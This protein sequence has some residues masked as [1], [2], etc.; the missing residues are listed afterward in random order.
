MIAPDK[1]ENGEF[2]HLIN[3]YLFNDRANIVKFDQYSDYY[4]NFERFFGNDIKNSAA[5][6][7]VD[8]LISSGKTFL[9][10]SDMINNLQ[11][12]ENEFET[13]IKGIFC[14]LNLLDYECLQ[15]VQKRLKIGI[16]YSF[17]NHDSESEFV[18]SLV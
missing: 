9:S 3:R 8:N 11:G 5:I 15:N 6:Y 14:L 12:I 16:I 10:L 2:L 4:L 18:L 7:Y 17:I 13:P 1:S